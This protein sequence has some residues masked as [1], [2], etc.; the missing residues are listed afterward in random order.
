MSEHYC[1]GAWVKGP[2]AD[3]PEPDHPVKLQKGT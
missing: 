2:R 3:C 1:K